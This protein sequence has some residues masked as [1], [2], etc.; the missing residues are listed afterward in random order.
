MDIIGQSSRLVSVDTA[1]PKI[2]VY[3]IDASLSIGTPQQVFDVSNC[4]KLTDR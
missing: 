3:E 2:S 1:K 4:F